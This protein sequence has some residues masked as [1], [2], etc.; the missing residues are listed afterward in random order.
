MGDPKKLK[1]QYKTPTQPWNSQTIEAEKALV[2]EYGLAKKK[3]IY[4]AD[5]FLKK[6]KD[7]AK[8]L[9]A[10]DSKQGKK[11]KEQMMTKL[12]GLGLLDATSELD[13]V[14]SLQLKDILE[15]RIQS[16]LF[17]KGL[18]RTIKQA[19]QFI[20]HE[21]VKLGDKSI[22]SPSYLITVEQAASL[23]FSPNS[24][25]V[26]EEH[27]ERY[28]EAAAIAQE[29]KETKA[30]PNTGADNNKEGPDKKSITKE[31]AQNKKAEQ[32]VSTAIENNKVSKEVKA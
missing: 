15:R 12:R 23:T 27:P 22:T 21:H 10:N 31:V 1:K 6:Y 14:L 29:V 16:Q 26:D 3:E 11:E 13:D 7:I 20:T 19:R 17:R 8:K 32:E 9:I 2:K 30:K 24:S 25:L 28:S 5:T 4:I 18:A